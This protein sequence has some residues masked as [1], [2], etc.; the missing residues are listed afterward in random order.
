MP[1]CSRGRPTLLCPLASGGNAGIHCSVSRR[2]GA[3]GGDE[4][5]RRRQRDRQSPTV[6]LAR[7]YGGISAAAGAPLRHL[8]RRTLAPRPSRRTL[9]PR[10]SRRAFRLLLSGHQACQGAILQHGGNRVP[11]LAH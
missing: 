5:W 10:H 1:R 2:R 9:A 6:R 4:A 11:R 7:D 3:D 8:F